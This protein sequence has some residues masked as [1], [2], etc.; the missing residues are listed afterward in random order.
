MTMTPLANEIEAL[1]KTYAA[2][3]RKDVGAAVEI[4]DPE[5]TWIEPSHYPEGGEHHGIE[6]VKALLTRALAKWAEGECTPE[7]FVAVG[8]KVLV[9]VHIHVRGKGKTDFI[10]GEHGSVYTFRNGKAIEM[11]IFDET[12]DAFE[13]VGLPYQE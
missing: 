11:R 4:F 2:H 6:A 1:R 3:N 9:V 8:D 5:V 12:P 13:W 7:R 10:D